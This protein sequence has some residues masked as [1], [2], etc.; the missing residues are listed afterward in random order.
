L[1]LLP[2]KIVCQLLSV[3]AAQQERQFRQ[4]GTTMACQGCGHP[5]NNRLC[6]PTCV[7]F[8]RTSF[9]CGQECFT[10]NWSSHSQ[11]HD[12]LR[13]K[14]AMANV[15]P[16]A[17]AETGGTTNSNGSTTQKPGKTENAAAVAHRKEIA[18]NR[19]RFSPL[20]G[21]TSLDSTLTGSQSKT[22][23]TPGGKKQSAVHDTGL[24]LVGGLVKRVQSVFA[25]PDTTGSAAKLVANR[26]D[27]PKKATLFPN[28]PRQ[29]A[30][31]PATSQPAK[32]SCVQWGVVGLVVVTVIVGGVFYRELHKPTD[33]HQFSPSGF[34]EPEPQ[35]QA[36]AAA[37]SEV[38]QSATNVDSASQ[39]R[40]LIEELGAMV[41]ELR[42]TVQRHD[43]MMRYIMDR[44]VEK[45]DAV[46]PSARRGNITVV[47]GVTLASHKA[48]EVNFSLPELLAS[49]GYGEAGHAGDTVRKRKGGNDAF[50]SVDVGL[51][52]VETSMGANTVHKPPVDIGAVAPEGKATGAHEA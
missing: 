38:G 34:L 22:A 28:Q 13:R 32:Q 16:P 48:S 23:S 46:L 49:Q 39:S 52:E 29:T 43:K 15:D 21:G 2:N 24:G 3:T 9:F 6:C 5:S 11:L 40:N 4:P 35:R 8:G 14:A 36:Q 30:T 26:K 45:G 42:E 50:A 51:P 31:P 17:D 10:K 41:A 7:E 27:L 37:S 20:P 33:E 19:K 1:C 18:G 25:E 12:I 44:Y 47:G